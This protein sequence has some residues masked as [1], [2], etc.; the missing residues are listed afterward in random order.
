MQLLVLALD[1][2]YDLQ[3]AL[4]IKAD[5]IAGDDTLIAFYDH[6]KLKKDIFYKESEQAIAA[7]KAAEEERKKKAADKALSSI[8]DQIEKF[9]GPVSPSLTFPHPSNPLVLPSFGFLVLRSYHLFNFR[10][11]EDSADI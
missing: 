2:V 5:G 9:E 6:N 10:N 8:E 11:S 7:A 1:A 3:K 4:R